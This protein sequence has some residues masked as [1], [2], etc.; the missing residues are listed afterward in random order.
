[1]AR[2]VLPTGERVNT[3]VNRLERNTAVS[4]LLG[5]TIIGHV[6]EV[7]A[8][9]ENTVHLGTRL[10]VVVAERLHSSSFVRGGRS[11]CGGGVS[12]G[13]GPLVPISTTNTR[14]ITCRVRV[15]FSER[16]QRVGNGLLT[17]GSV[18]GHSGV[19]HG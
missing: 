19:T 8:G 14:E 6:E 17:G 10:C 2:L 1:M 7:A 15:H 11:I 3:I 12:K 5:G 13:G 18:D 16:V 4:V 9:S